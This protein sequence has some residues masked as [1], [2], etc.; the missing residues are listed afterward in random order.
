M[1]PNTPN[2]LGSGNINSVSDLQENPKVKLKRAGGSLSTI[3]W[4]I[5]FSAGHLQSSNF[6]KQGK[7]SITSHLLLLIYD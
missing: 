7:I 6:L 1:K 5:L 4:Y 3:L 2:L